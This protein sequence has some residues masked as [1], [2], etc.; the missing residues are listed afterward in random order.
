MKNFKE[1]KTI[2]ESKIA[3]VLQQSIENWYN[4]SNDEME[5]LTELTGLD[6]ETIVSILLHSDYEDVMQNLM[7]A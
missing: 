4:G 2:N 5:T 6:E 7:N 1:F 3:D